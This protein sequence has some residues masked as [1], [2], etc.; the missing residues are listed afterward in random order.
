MQPTSE[1]RCLFVFHALRASEL[2]LCSAGLVF[3]GRFLGKR[4]CCLQQTPGEDSLE[5]ATQSANA[6]GQSPINRLG[7]IWS[8]HWL[9]GDLQLL[10][11][12]VCSWL[13]DRNNCVSQLFGTCALSSCGLQI[14]QPVTMRTRTRTR[15]RKK[16]TFAVSQSSRLKCKSLVSRK[17]S[18]GPKHVPCKPAGGQAAKLLLKPP[19]TWKDCVSAVF[20]RLLV[21][22]AKV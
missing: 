6:S 10:H 13:P 9:K 15:A 16:H 7:L 3:L 1:G 21:G 11:L 4:I 8:Q 20:L 22:K 17:P 14:N 2:T 12:R 5:I 18:V 19:T